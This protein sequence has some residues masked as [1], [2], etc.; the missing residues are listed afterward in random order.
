[1]A[2]LKNFL[3][4]LR[5]NR[6]DSRQVETVERIAIIGHSHDAVGWRPVPYT[7][8]DRFEQFLSSLET[9]IDTLI[10]KANP[11]RYN[12]R[13]YEETINNEV[14]LALKELISQRTD[15]KR[16]IHNIRIYQQASLTDIENHLRSMEGA[17][18]GNKEVQ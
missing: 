13:F 5:P 9:D 11:D 3:D 18:S 8:P 14:E 2:K 17:L 16:S 7:T 1:M 4:K 6:T 15:H 10:S 12:A